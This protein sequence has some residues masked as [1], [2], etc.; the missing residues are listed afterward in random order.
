MRTILL[1]FL[2][3]CCLS[4]SFGQTNQQDS[5]TTY[6]LVIGISD[7]K[8]PGIPDLEFTENDATAFFNYLT[9][10]AGGKLDKSN[11]KLLLNQSA[12][13]GN[14][15]SKLDEIIGN[16]NK[17]D[18]FIFYFAGHGGA[19]TTTE[20]QRGY[21]LCYDTPHDNYKIGALSIKDLEDVISTLEIQ[22][23]LS[24][25]ILDIKHEVGEAET[26]IIGQESIV[27]HLSR[28]FSSEVK[29]LACK[30]Y[31]FSQGEEQWGGIH[32]IF[33]YFLITGLAGMADMDGDNAVTLF[34]LMIYLEEQ[35][36]EVV[37]LDNQKPVLV[38]NQARVLSFITDSIKLESIESIF[39]TNPLDGPPDSPDNNNVV[40]DS[41]QTHQ[42]NGWGGQPGPPDP[43]NWDT[44]N[45]VKQSPSQ[46]KEKPDRFDD[47][48]PQL[49][50]LYPELPQSHALVTTDDS[51]EI[52]L[53][54]GNSIDYL[55]INQEKHGRLEAESHSFKVPL[56]SGMNEIQVS[57]TR[58][59]RTTVDTIFVYSKH[60]PATRF[61]LDEPVYYYGLFI[62][63][64]QYNDPDI[65]D[66]SNPVF[67]AREVASVLAK[68]YGF[69]IDTLFNP[70]KTQI[71]LKL[72]EYAD[73]FNDKNY[74]KNN[75]HLLI[76]FSGHGVLDE[77]YRQYHWVA[78]DSK[79]N[80]EIYD[81]YLSAAD[82]N[83]KFDNLK[84]KH[85]M[86]VVDACYSGTFNLDVAAN[87]DRGVKPAAAGFSSKISAAW[88]KQTFDIQTRLLVA[89]GRDVPVSDGNKG[90][91]SPFAYQL[92][93]ALKSPPEDGILTKETF[94]P[95]FRNCTPPPISTTF[96]KQNQPGSNFIFLKKD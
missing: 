44:I 46:T 57:A 16:S 70:T 51:L 71:L 55:Y 1:S 50:V 3:I 39:Y 43:Y 89:S 20:N 88:V 11:V 35:F 78:A 91:H 56:K 65:P 37:G 77:I 15:Y 83:N 59:F 66:L 30:P 31:E 64:D 40:R 8:D 81:S 67:D 27:E 47:A 29:M 54:A 74:L 23:V 12:T 28:P 68:D 90:Q 73:R 53:E 52:Q 10:P 7:Y 80:D 22:L 2:L 79:A 94:Q 75:D 26:E 17:G 49:I 69:E 18:K 93:E 62:G 38:G 32:G 82:L 85:V 96:G 14:I 42:T 4:Y 19:D 9:S 41:S 5:S 36:S 76:Y 21:L 33:T 60:A 6:A 92:L 63:I 95:Y 25:L 24:T 34:E 61:G 86:L 58:G 45:V 72:R 87:V 13:V 48:A 84:I